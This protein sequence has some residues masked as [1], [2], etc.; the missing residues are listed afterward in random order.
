MC[1]KSFGLWSEF[2]CVPADSC[3]LIPEGMTY[4]EAAAVP[5]NYI[6]A[7]HMLFC[8]GSLHKG[9]SVLVHMAAGKSLLVCCYRFCEMSGRYSIKLLGLHTKMTLT[10][11]LVEVIYGYVQKIEC[12][13]GVSMFI[14]RGNVSRLLSLPSLCYVPLIYL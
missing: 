10:L 8:L 2:V 14:Y 3:G 11:T 7:Y 4:E 1:M 6:T 5:V 9:Q 13:S 12:L